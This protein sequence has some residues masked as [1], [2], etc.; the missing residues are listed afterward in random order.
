M[1]IIMISRGTYSGGT[2]LAQLVAA[3]VGAPCLSRE[4][5]IEEA[6]AR[7]RLPVPDIEAAM[8]KRPPFWHRLLGERTAYLT[9]VRAALCEHARGGNL[10]YHGY[11][12]HLLLPGIAH[13][14]RVRVTAD[15]EFRLQAALVEHLTREAAHAHITR[16]DRE[17][18]EWSRFL[19]GVDWEDPL[20]YDLILN[21]SRI[22]VGAA[23]AAVVQAATHPNFQPTAASAKALH[24]LVLQ[25]RVAA[26]LAADPR[27]ADASVTVVADGGRITITGQ[28]RWPD[29]ME[30]ISQ[31]AE[32]VADVKEVTAQ[33]SYMAVPYAPPLVA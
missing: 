10:V 4:V 33:L 8:D 21:L 24:D 29:G 26:A 7:S 25:S 31:I 1:A 32:Q 17:R 23:S 27:T 16:V 2:T 19:F 3:R 30:P 14:L 13:V 11:V 18:R 15:L 22:T 28:V 12:G 9:F 20:L 5:I 6:A